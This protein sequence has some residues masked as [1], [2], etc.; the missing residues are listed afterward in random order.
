MLSSVASHAGDVESGS[1]N[2]LRQRGGDCSDSTFVSSC[3]DSSGGCTCIF[4]DGLISGGPFGNGYGRVDLN[5]NGNPL[6][7]GCSDYNASLFII[8]PGD[9]QEVDFSG[10]YCAKDEYSGR[11]SGS[12]TIALSASGYTGTGSI[13]GKFART[14]IALQFSGPVSRNPRN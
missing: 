8:A 9:L 13:S 10:S 3:P 11:F 6:T 12:Y 4:S 2:S 7:A 5:V 1:F 14:K